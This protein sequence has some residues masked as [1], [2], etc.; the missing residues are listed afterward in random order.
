MIN[1]H[2]G[3]VPGGNVRQAWRAILVQSGYVKVVDVNLIVIPPHA[4]IMRAE[5]DISV[6][7]KAFMAGCQG[8]IPDF[9]V[10]ANRR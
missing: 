8:Q 3:S 9:I 5:S 7:I 6:R 2:S 1:D 10:L 4:I